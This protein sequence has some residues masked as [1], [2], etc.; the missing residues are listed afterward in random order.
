MA[1]R[2]GGKK[3]MKRVT[4]RPAAS[5]PKAS[6]AVGPRA[7]PTS[8]PPRPPKGRPSQVASLDVRLGS[9][10]ESAFGREI[11]ETCNRCSTCPTSGPGRSCA[12]ADEEERPSAGNRRHRAGAYSSGEQVGRCADEVRHRNVGFH[13]RRCL[14]G[15]G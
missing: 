10:S 7:T 14:R 12:C 3:L 15:Y 8:N 4:L 11:Y 9:G 2:K 1:P 13:L 6:P 5:Y